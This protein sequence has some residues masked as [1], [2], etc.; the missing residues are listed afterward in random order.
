MPETLSD[1]LETGEIRRRLSVLP[2]FTDL[3]DR[4]YTPP[5]VELKPKLIPKYSDLLILDQ[6]ED[7]ACVGFA[8]AAVI[9]HLRGSL[10]GH[11]VSPQMLYEMA[12]LN[13][14]WRDDLEQVGSSVRGGLK[15]FFHNGVCSE[16]LAPF[17]PRQPGDPAWVLSH[18]QA[19]EA[20]QTTLGAYYRLRPNITDY[21]TALNQTG[22]ILVSAQT[23]AGWVKPQ[24]HKGHIRQNGRRGGGH[25]VA[26]IGY[27]DAGFI[28]QNSWGPDWG[29]FSGA[30]G[31]AHW[32]YADWAN[33]IIDAWVLRLS[34]SSPTAFGLSSGSTLNNSKTADARK[35]V[36]A[37][38]RA[39]EVR[40]H[41]LHVEDGVFV[42]RGRYPSDPAQAQEVVANI[43]RWAKAYR[44]Q[45]RAQEGAKEEAHILIYLHGGMTGPKAG[46][47]RARAM[48]PKFL[49]NGIYPV[50]ILWET[51]FNQ[52]FFDVLSGIDAQIDQRS[53]TR[54]RQ[55][56]QVFE[57]L[58]RRI[59]RRL[60]ADLKLS[61]DRSLAE[62]TELTQA[63]HAMTQVAKDQGLN[64][65]FMAHSAG[66]Y[67]LGHW[68]ARHGQALE[69]RARTSAHLT[70]PACTVD[71]YQ[72]TIAPALEKGQINSLDQFVLS[73]E[74]ELADRIGTYDKSVLHLIHRA[75]EG[76]RTGPANHHDTH[77]SGRPAILGL[78]EG[79]EGL[80]L[81][82]HHRVHVAGARRA[83]CKA[84]TH[85]G[86]DQDEATMNKILTTILT[87]R[88]SAR[89]QFQPHDF[90]G[91]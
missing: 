38:P 5:L 24:R 43:A 88:P 45:G 36:A 62:G 14:E 40:D 61:A 42:R 86:F 66:A 29:Q 52:D 57:R 51:G 10:P 18:A 1:T 47:M 2:D 4:I 64:I 76:G 3:R 33:S 7:G 35:P 87:R 79:L 71:F 60:W 82:Q 31:V 73:P 41:L 89:R 81:A 59:G 9:N 25:A 83:A 49:H 46:A 23:H 63:L 77:A 54:D 19:Q 44:A 11:G 50:H 55:H 91:Y 6:G 67:L 65:H 8:L 12:K 39:F 15:G 53:D 78:H 27:D 70:A 85:Q 69:G 58:A 90:W 68:L 34:I 72:E 26:I 75:F 17:V 22:A 32:S 28:I 37:T 84:E 56:P 30:A 16:Q 13:D 21:H 80:E 20:T 48:R 74:R